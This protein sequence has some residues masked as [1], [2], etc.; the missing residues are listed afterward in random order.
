MLWTNCVP[1]TLH[2]C[3]LAHTINVAILGNR[4]FKL[5][6]Q[7]LGEDIVKQEEGEMSGVHNCKAAIHKGKKF[8][9]MHSHWNLES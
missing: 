8:Q 4:S 9:H 7:L 6:K 3:I 5:N 1:Y 2:L